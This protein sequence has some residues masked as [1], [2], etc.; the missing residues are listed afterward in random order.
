MN[1]QAEIDGERGIAVMLFH[2][3]GSVESLVV[4]LTSVS[5]RL[6]FSL[7][8]FSFLTWIIIFLLRL[9]L[10]RALI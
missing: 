8:K 10:A 2:V 9:M 4:F 7:G 6:N 5:Q 1:D 3:E